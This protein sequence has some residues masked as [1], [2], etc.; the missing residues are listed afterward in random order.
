MG[1][2]EMVTLK[3]GQEEAKSAVEVVMISLRNLMKNDPIC[4]YELVMKCRDR[5]HV[6]FWKTWHKLNGLWLVEDGGSINDSIRNV[7]LSAVTW[8]PFNMELGSPIE[9]TEKAIYETLN[10]ENEKKISEEQKSI[11]KLPIDDQQKKYNMIIE[12]D[13]EEEDYGQ[14]NF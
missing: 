12:N 6:F 3:N 11:N 8:E 14:Y 1:K 4:F 5:N 9:K 13:E 7:V 2:I 10:T